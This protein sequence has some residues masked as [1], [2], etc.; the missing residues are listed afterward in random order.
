LFDWYGRRTGNWNGPRSYQAWDIRRSLEACER[1]TGWRPIAWRAHSYK[2]DPNTYPLLAEMGVRVVSDQIEAD[3]IWPKH[4]QSGLISHP[5]NVI[6]DHDHL[7]HAHRTQEF[8]E[9]ARRTGYGAD[10]FGTDSYTIQQWGE[11]VLKQ[12]QAIEA[13]DGL[14]TVL[15]HPIC[16]YLSDGFETLETLL[17]YFATR[18]SIWAREI[19]E[20]VDDSPLGLQDQKR[21]LATE[22]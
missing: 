7:Y 20:L 8:V 21:D 14:V 12:A 3:N 4:I 9:R 18:Q 19:V 22:G 6:P 13:K 2:V 10:E 16:M 15:A 17:Q 1:M 11:L 5:M